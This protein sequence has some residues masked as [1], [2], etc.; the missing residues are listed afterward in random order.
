MA[1][2]AWSMRAT[3]S[4]GTFWTAIVIHFLHIFLVPTDGFSVYHELDQH[5]PT[6]QNPRT[7]CVCGESHGLGFPGIESLRYPRILPHGC[8]ITVTKWQFEPQK[9]LSQPLV[10]R[11]AQVLQNLAGT[12]KAYESRIRPIARISNRAGASEA[13]DSRVSDLTPDCKEFGLRVTAPFLTLLQWLFGFKQKR[14][15]CLQTALKVN[16]I[17][18]GILRCIPV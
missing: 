7:G 1:L 16:G 4:L 10:S 9:S 12:C 14:E 13:I 17:P 8:Q 2:M 3:S 15:D 11:Y 18:T 5:E 6:P